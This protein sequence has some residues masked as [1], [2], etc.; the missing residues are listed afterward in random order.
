MSETPNP[1]DED[2][3]EEIDFSQG[4]RGQFYRPGAKLD[5]PLY[6]DP[7]LQQRLATLAR[8][9]GVELSTLVNELLTQDVDRI[10]G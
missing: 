7:A 5:L 10:A 2:L 9:R 1:D 8:A 6:L 3:P 4:T